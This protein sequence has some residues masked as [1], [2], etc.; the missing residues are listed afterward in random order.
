[1]ESSNESHIVSLFRKQGKP[2][3]TAT[4]F[5]TASPSGHLHRSVP[6]V[7]SLPTADERNGFEMRSHY[8]DKSIHA[9]TLERKISARSVNP[10]AVKVR[11][12]VT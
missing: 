12:M 1:M 3:M 4:M 10:A 9:F 11:R 2:Q 7:R 8:N 6:E 5:L